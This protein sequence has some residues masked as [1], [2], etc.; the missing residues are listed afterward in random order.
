MESAK[1]QLRAEKEKNSVQTENIRELKSH[2]DSATSKLEEAKSE[3][4]MAGIQDDEKVA[5]FKVDVEYIYP[6]TGA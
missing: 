1:T 4:V 5:Q 3:V 6:K 2:L